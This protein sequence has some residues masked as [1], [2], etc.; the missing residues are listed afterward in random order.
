MWNSG[1]AG[2][3]VHSKDNTVSIVTERDRAMKHIE[4]RESMA[5]LSR[6][7]YNEIASQLIVI[8]AVNVIF[9]L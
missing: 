3:F 5:C 6:D 2:V 9:S 8:F 1:I 4:Q 7:A